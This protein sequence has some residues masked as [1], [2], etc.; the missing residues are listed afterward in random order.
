MKFSLSQKHAKPLQAHAERCGR[1]VV[2]QLELLLILLYGLDDALPEYKQ[3]A[4]LMRRALEVPSPFNGDFTA[5]SARRDGRGFPQSWQ[6]VC[7]QAA[8]SLFQLEQFSRE[9][10]E[11]TFTLSQG[12][13]VSL[14]KEMQ[15]ESVMTDAQMR[16]PLYAEYWQKRLDEVPGEGAA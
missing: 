13:M 15:P 16:M 3:A 10:S 5:R 11:D 6:E 1:S 7:Q 9:L 12:L 8:A 2:Q 14:L 4:Q